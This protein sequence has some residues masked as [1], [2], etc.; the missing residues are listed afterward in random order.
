MLATPAPELLAFERA[1]ALATAEPMRATAGLSD[2]PAVAEASGGVECL[3]LSS[4]SSRLAGAH[5]RRL[6]Q[7]RRKAGLPTC[8]A[9]SGDAT[10]APDSGLDGVCA[11]DRGKCAQG[12]DPPLLRQR[13]QGVR[14]GVAASPQSEEPLIWDDLTRQSGLSPKQRRVMAESRDV[15]LLNGVS[16]PLHGPG[17]ETYVSASPP[18]APVRRKLPIWQSCNPGRAV[19]DF[20]PDDAPAN[21]RVSDLPIANANASPGRREARVPGASARSS[22]SLSTR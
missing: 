14:S 1:T 18:E 2:L 11:G 17:G 3:I 16:I 19:S 20:L 12:M 21:C 8:G 13:L 9:G 15:G 22:V 5:L 10:G 7:R 4:Q 6:P